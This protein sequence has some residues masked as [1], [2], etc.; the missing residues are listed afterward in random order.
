MN[1]EY[2]G[3]KMN[4]FVQIPRRSFYNFYEGQLNLSD[5]LVLWW[6]YFRANPTRASLNTSYNQL[7]EELGGILKSNYLKKILH[8]LKIEKYIWFKNHKGKKGLFSIWIDAYHMST[9]RISKIDEVIQ[10]KTKFDDSQVFAPI[11]KFKGIDDIDFTDVKSTLDKKEFTGFYK[12]NHNDSDK[13]N[14]KDNDSYA[15]DSENNLIKANDGMNPL[16]KGL[17]ERYGDYKG[18]IESSKKNEEPPIS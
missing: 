12:D 15:K 7:T 10:H 16:R 8:K 5:L 14:H 2:K 17:K 9:G 13:L 11:H 4:D 1:D 6:L 18:F 3:E